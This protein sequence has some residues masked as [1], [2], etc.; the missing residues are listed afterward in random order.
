MISLKPDHLKRYKDIATLLIRYG[1]SD[2][3]RRMKG[4]FPDLEAAESSESAAMPEEFA[5]DLEKLGPTYIKLGQLMSTQTAM[6]PDAY[7]LALEELQD[8]VESFPFEEVEKAIFE[9]LG[10]RPRKIFQSIDPEPL[11]AASLS[12]VHR[13]ITHDGAEVVV[14]V[15]R[16]GMRRIVLGDLE[17]LDE[18]AGFLE[19]NSS[20]GRHFRLREQLVELRAALL[21]ELDYRQE[22]RNMAL[23][24]INLAGFGTIRIPKAL[25]S[26]SSEKI[27]TMEYVAGRKITT[28]SPLARLEVDGEALAG[29]LY[30]AFIKQILVDG[31]VHVDPHPGNVY[32]TEDNRLALLDF[33]MVGHIP[34]QMQ[35]QLTKLLVS[36]SDGRGED[37]AE[38]ALRMGRRGD[39]FD[40]VK[41]R[42]LTAGM[43]AEF[44]S[45]KVADIA[46]GRLFLSIA[47][48]SESAGV[49]PPAQFIMLGKTLL[50]LDRVAKSLSPSFNPNETVRR[51][52]AE[53]LQS[54]IQGGLSLGKLYNTALET[55]EF[56]QQLPGKLNALMEMA[57]NNELKVKVETHDEDRL[58]GGLQKIANR[59]TMGLVLA[60]LIIGAA[61]LMRVDTP[62]KLAGYPGLAVLLFLGACIGGV[63]Q[64]ASIVGGDRKPRPGPA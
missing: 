28:L 26:Y 36:I 3:A 50:K 59:I 20:K 49:S 1:N 45:L 42:D 35:T 14:K 13:A 10:A 40:P 31:M 30:R 55:N 38:L 5:R 60:A 6:I 18:L 46:V 58:I 43:V 25:E 41:W 54:R 51:C 37:A 9:E 24:A 21:R 12:Q 29:E 32:L 15:Q 2:L 63:A 52:S 22:A 11:A 61:L 39:A 57:V 16:P 56:V 48:I 27:L 34:P 64:I 44:R 7:I 23:M 53:L 8:R 4:E 17:M 33:G 19:R 62:F 47:A